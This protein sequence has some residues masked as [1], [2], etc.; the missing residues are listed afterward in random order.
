MINFDIF[1]KKFKGKEWLEVNL[2]PIDKITTIIREY[3]A[4]KNLEFQGI[5]N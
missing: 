3:L 4:V 2:M 5:R 1:K